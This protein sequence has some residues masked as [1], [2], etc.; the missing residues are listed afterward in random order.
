M[1]DE[2]GVPA[3]VVILGEVEVDVGAVSDGFGGGSDAV[4]PD[5]PEERV[6]GG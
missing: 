2:C 6:H 1:L 4:V 3:D 5:G